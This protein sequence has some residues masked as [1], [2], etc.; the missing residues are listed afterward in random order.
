MNRPHKVTILT[1]EKLIFASK[2]PVDI[3]LA[4]ETSRI[5]E[6]CKRKHSL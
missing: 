6:G 3:P 5:N 2:L 4:M 1:I